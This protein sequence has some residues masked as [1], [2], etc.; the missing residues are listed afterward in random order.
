[1]EPEHRYP[2]E[3]FDIDPEALDLELIKQSQ[4]V[5][6]YGFLLAK[7]ERSAKRAQERVKVLRSQLVSKARREGIPGNKSDKNPTAQAIEAYYRQDPEYREAKNVMIEA[8]FQADICRNMISALHHK[9]EALTNLVK[10]LSLNYFSGPG[11]PKNLQKEVQMYEEKWKELRSQR[12]LDVES[13]YQQRREN[14]RR[15]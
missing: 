6:Q 12:M 5:A 4:L 15:N 9:R 8:E 10:L 14:R 7:A 11:I 2:I 13:D 1:M 3:D